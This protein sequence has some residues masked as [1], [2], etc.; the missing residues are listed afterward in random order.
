MRNKYTIALFLVG[1][2]MAA[3]STYTPQKKATLTSE[4]T[5]CYIER[6]GQAYDSVPQ[7][8][9]AIDLYSDGLSLSDSARRM[10]GTGVNLYLS[11][12]FL[13]DTLFSTGDYVSDTTGAPYTFLPG[14]NFDGSPTGIYLLS[15]A[16]G[17]LSSI[18]VLDSGRLH[19]A[20]TADS[21]YDMQFTLYY[22]KQTYEAHFSGAAEYYDRRKR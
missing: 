19:V 12:L 22:G 7:Q 6:Y 15:V 20:Q 17:Q 16:D 8:V 10:Q 18:L 11:D 3:C 21:L 14:R 9:F 1:A 4:F 13:A 2:V 5:T